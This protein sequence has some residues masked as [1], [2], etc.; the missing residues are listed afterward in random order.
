MNTL[1]RGSIHPSIH[2]T[3]SLPVYLSIYLSIYPS[4]HPSIHPCIHPFIY[5]FI[6]LSNL[7]IPINIHSCLYMILMLIFLTN[8]RIFKWDKPFINWCRISSIHSIFVFSD[9]TSFLFQLY[10]TPRTSRCPKR[11]SGIKA[12]SGAPGGPSGGPFLGSRGTH[13]AEYIRFSCSALSAEHVFFPPG[14]ALIHIATSERYFHQFDHFSSPY[15][16]MIFIM[17]SL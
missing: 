11:G 13:A 1:L 9:T 10:S 8:I 7:Y 4:C 12:R 2:S 5:L 16:W 17:T 3:F 14:L 6:C 15:I